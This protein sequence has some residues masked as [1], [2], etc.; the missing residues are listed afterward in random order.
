M[1]VPEDIGIAQNLVAQGYFQRVAAGDQRA[2]S[3][4][5]RLFAH[6]ANPSGSP[7]SWGRLKKGGGTAVDGYAEDA[8]CYGSDQ[9]DLHNVV[10]LVIGAGAPGA[11]LAP[12][13]THTVE[14]RPV[15]TWELPR[16]LSANEVNYLKGFNPA[17]PEPG[18]NCTL[19]VSLFWLLRGVREHPDQLRENLRWA[20]DTLGADYVRGIAVVGGDLF[21]GADPWEFAGAFLRWPDWDS[22]LAHATDLCFDIY[23]LRVQWTLFGSRGQT[24]LL[25]ECEQVVD[26]F[27]AAMQ[28]RTHKLHL[29]EVWNEYNVNGAS[30]ADLRHLARRLRAGLPGSVPIALS[31]PGTVHACAT[32]AEI[33]TEVAKLYQGLPEA[34]AITPHWCRAHHVV[35]SLGPAAP[36]I[37][38]SNEPRGPG[39]SAGGDVDDP[40]LLAWDYQAAIGAG[41]RGYVY[42]TLGGIWGGRCHPN[43][44]QENRWPNLFSSHGAAETARRLKALRQGGSAPAPGP[45]P[46]PIPPP[47]TPPYPDE[48]T[49]WQAYEA[50][51][52]ALY[53]QAGQDLP[54]VVFEAGRWFSRPG[55]S[56][57]SGMDKDVAKAKHLAELRAALGLP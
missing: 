7:A 31:S 11:R 42:H 18:H 29:V 35:P 4:F 1:A 15:D 47:S 40:G 34:D 12:T 51:V 46:P 26:R 56:I 9:Q 39:A 48:P 38:Y 5:A 50:E 21:S 22:Q 24:P 53:R 28:G 43:W 41:Y 2:A 45:S 32:A 19:G 49:W 25:S 23:R 44:P 37:Q 36:A 6:A 54:D 30:T 14:R 16:P 17:P 8:V 33:H 55:Y 27:L 52:A 3:L 10:D 13:T 20:R 57:G